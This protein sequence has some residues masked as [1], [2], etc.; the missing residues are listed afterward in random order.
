MFTPPDN[1]KPGHG[2][3]FL[4]L[5]LKIAGQGKAVC[6]VL[7]N[8]RWLDRTH[9][10]YSPSN[11]AALDSFLHEK[12]ISTEGPK[13]LVTMDKPTALMA[14][15]DLSDPLGGADGVWLE[16]P[17]NDWVDEEIIAS[18]HAAGKTA[19][20]MSPE[21]HGRQLDL[22]VVARWAASDGVCTD[23]PHLL[24]RVLDPADKVVHP[25]EPWW[26]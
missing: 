21:L 13:R 19:W 10:F 24:A 16:Q 4:F 5:H 17:E 7:R 6:E 25:K 9:V 22:G 11:D 26:V 15:L 8:R 23:F 20:V 3:G 12:P 18:V 1:A 2:S 14:L